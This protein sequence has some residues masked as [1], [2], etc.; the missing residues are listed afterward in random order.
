MHEVCVTGA[1]RRLDLDIPFAGRLRVGDLRQHHGSAGR[2]QHAELPSSD[3]PPGLGTPPH[4][5]QNDLC[6]TCR[7][8]IVPMNT[9]VGAASTYTRSCIECGAM[10][11]RPAS[12]RARIHLNPGG[13][14]AVGS[15]RRDAPIRHALNSSRRR[16]DELARRTGAELGGT[17][18]CVNAA[19]PAD[20]WAR[21][22]ENV[23][24][25]LQVVDSMTEI[26][27]PL[28][29]SNRLSDR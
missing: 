13:R 8:L 22:R 1:V 7:L 23:G 28:P 11:I 25:H 15:L 27:N 6:R 24:H 2:E 19:Q 3:Q 4:F 5:L 12:G 20:Q 17:P 14:E 21:T 10:T 26:G 16:A 18:Q 9:V 29:W